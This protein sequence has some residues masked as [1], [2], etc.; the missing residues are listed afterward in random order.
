MKLSIENKL[1]KIYGLPEGEDLRFVFKDNQREKDKEK[2]AENPLPY[3]IISQEASGAW[4]LYTGLEG[5]EFEQLEVSEYAFST[6]RNIN[7]IDVRFKI[8]EKNMMIHI[9]IPLESWEV[10]ALYKDKGEKLGEV[11]VN[12]LEKI[13]Y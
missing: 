10:V 6:K 7:E 11:I 1:P 12:L 3:Y 13:V 8:N 9:P 4:K 2:Q 5:Q